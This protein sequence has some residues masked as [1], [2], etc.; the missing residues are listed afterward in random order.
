MSQIFIPEKIR[1][2]FQ[3]RTDTYTGKLGYVIYYDEKG[4]I[5]KE[6]SWKSWCDAKQGVL[7]LDNSPRSGYILNKGVK[8]YGYFN[9]GRSVIRMYDPRDFEFEIS[10]DNL[11]A[12]FMHSNV[13]KR[14]IEEECVFAWAG[15]ELVLLPVVSE[16]YQQAKAYT[17]KQSKSLSTKDFVPGHIYH[18]KKEEHP[19]VYLGYHEWFVEKYEYSQN[20]YSGHMVTKSTGK[21]HIFYN[22]KYSYAPFSAMSASQLSEHI[23]TVSPDYQRA[24]KKF[25]NSKESGGKLKVS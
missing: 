5:R 24:L 17:E 6:Q 23:E 18:A 13:S 14:D 15:S 11:V 21:K 12:I 4:K 10:V 3:K 7:E 25:A 2:G 19:L 22:S 16:E 9:S 8:R 20:R 1:V